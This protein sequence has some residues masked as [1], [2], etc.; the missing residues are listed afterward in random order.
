MVTLACAGILLLLPVSACAAEPTPAPT[1]APPTAAPVFAT[2]EEALAAAEEAYAN[3][4]S[5]SSAI[6]H[7]GGVDAQLMTE[8]ATG[9]A[10]ETEIGSFE[11]MSKAGT[12]GVGELQFDTL[13]VQSLDL[14]S[15]SLSA[16]VCLDVS[17]SDVVDG[18]GVSTLSEG[19]VERLPLEI[20]FVYDRDG[21]RLLLERT[22]TWDGENFC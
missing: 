4:L 13:T 9:E 3:Y 22:R 19:R 11:E 5:R 10:L 8:V 16:Y 18:S 21:G 14:S 7:G 1:S 6:A 12:V 20:G 17:G 2:D 15:G